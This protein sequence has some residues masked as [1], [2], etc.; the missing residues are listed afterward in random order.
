[1]RR[2][3]GRSRGCLGHATMA[4]PSWLTLLSAGAVGF[5]VLAY[6]LLDGT[7]LGV[8]MLVAL[9][10]REAHRQVMVLS[11][12]PVWDA[13][14]TWL[15]L[16]GGGLLALFP[17]AYALLLPALYVPFMVMFAAL[18]LRAM[19]LEFREHVSRKRLADAVLVLGSLIATLAQGLIMGTLLQGITWAPA[20]TGGQFNGSG[21][22]WLRPFPLFCAVAHVS[23]YLWLGSCW[24]YWRTQGPLQGRSKSQAAWLAPIAVVLVASVVAWASLLNEHYAERL[25]QLSLL[26]P[27]TGLVAAL[28]VLFALGLRRR[29]D[30]LPL[31]AALGMVVVGFGL[32]AFAVFPLIVPPALTLAQAAA[33]P[34]TQI[35]VLVGFAVWVPITLAYNTFGFSLFAGK[36]RG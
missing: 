31:V 17:Q 20:A 33:G 13:N 9:E 22:E 18:V 27:A 5:S 36:I 11:I 14:E 34:R 24:L 15:V 12:L 23:G 19:A 28:M 8:G 35:F 16:G 21:W 1:M 7:D 32:L 3:P 30:A 26:P 4:E 6:V 10:R 25:L 2:K 29:R